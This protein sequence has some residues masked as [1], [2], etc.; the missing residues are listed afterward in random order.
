MV[1]SAQAR[2]WTAA[3]PISGLP[4]M[5]V[6][7][8]FPNRQCAHQAFEYLREV[9]LSAPLANV[10]ETSREILRATKMNYVFQTKGMRFSS[11]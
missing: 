1:F 8:L 6:L 4:I 9:D 5:D 2:L 7:D 10:L 11:K 3:Q